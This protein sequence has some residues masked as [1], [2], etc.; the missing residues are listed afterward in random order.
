MAGQI[1][2]ALIFAIP[3]LVILFGF[4][5]YYVPRWY[6]QRGD[7]ETGPFSI[8]HLG[9]M[10][11]TNQIE[12]TDQIR[13]RWSK[14]ASPFTILT[15][16]APRLL[17]AIIGCVLGAG[18]G[19]GVGMA[20][21]GKVE[22]LTD[23][24]W[25]QPEWLIQKPGPS[26]FKQWLQ[27]G[28]RVGSAAGK[29]SFIPGVREAGG[30]L[31]EGLKAYDEMSQATVISQAIDHIRYAILSGGIG[32]ALLFALAAKESYSLIRG[33][34]LEEDSFEDEADAPISPE[35]MRFP[36]PACKK[37]LT[38]L[39]VHAGKKVNCSGCKKTVRIPSI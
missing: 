33:R 27:G 24:V 10:L 31:G 3:V 8:C 11:R 37:P 4:W 21:F 2:P 17:S 9:R 22:S 20:M 30:A 14:M 23:T 1:I 28:I 38:V 16:P 18:V 6:L 7:V 25:V 35:K 15:H 12:K 5:S 39:R 32:A 34:K 29:E 26:Q 19:L 13:K 36:C